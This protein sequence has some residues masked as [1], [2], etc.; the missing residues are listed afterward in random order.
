MF[1]QHLHVGT[2]CVQFK[3]GKAIFLKNCASER[4]M[5]K[6]NVLDPDLMDKYSENNFSLSF[7]CAVLASPVDSQFS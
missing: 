4:I 3:T 2:R 1:N 7:S 5:M 6:N